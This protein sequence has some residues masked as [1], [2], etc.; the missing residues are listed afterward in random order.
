MAG[1]PPWVL[2]LP[3]PS[4][5]GHLCCSLWKISKQGAIIRVSSK[6]FNQHTQIFVGKDFTLA[7]CDTE[8]T[9]EQII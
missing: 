3:S 8:T 9:E 1:P 4:G 2:P 7:Y 6:G 5:I